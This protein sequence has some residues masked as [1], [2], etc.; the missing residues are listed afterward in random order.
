MEP[1]K[2]EAEDRY[3]HVRF[4]DP[5]KYNVIRTPDWADNVS[6]SVSEGSE[7]RMGKLKGED[8]WEI[9]AVLINKNAGREKAV[10]QARK[11]V[12]KIRS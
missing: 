7:V 11:I 10:E 12:E 5:E 8:D 4:N 1:E 9:Q 3:F 6:D 2:V